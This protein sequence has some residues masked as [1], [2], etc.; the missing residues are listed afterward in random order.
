[1]VPEGEG[2]ER[3]FSRSEHLSHIRQETPS[4]P[5]FFMSGKGEGILMVHEKG[6]LPWTPEE[7][8]PYTILGQIRGTY[9][10]CEGQGDLIFIDQHAAHERI[11]FEEFKKKYKNKSMV[12]ER[13]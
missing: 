4:A 8:W 11:L 2:G 12:S 5:S 13:L 6:A 7:K 3:F 9:I 10:L 1:M